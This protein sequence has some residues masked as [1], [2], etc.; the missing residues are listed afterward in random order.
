MNGLH[1]LIKNFLKGIFIDPFK[2]R[3][4][5]FFLHSI[6]PKSQYERLAHPY[7][8]F[9]N[10]IMYG[11]MKLHIQFNSFHFFGPSLPIQY[12]WL[13]NEQCGMINEMVKQ[14]ELLFKTKKE[15]QNDQCDYYDMV[16]PEQDFIK[17]YHRRQLAR[18]FVW[19]IYHKK[20]PYM[21]LELIAAIQSILVVHNSDVF[22]A[23]LH[24]AL[25]GR[26][27]IT[28]VP[29]W[30]IVEWDKHPDELG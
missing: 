21:L 12:K 30:N 17:L 22:M 4:F 10:A 8:D 11:E 14:R 13:N 1:D 26:C 16:F 27:L 6:R 23:T 18:D 25:Q 9:L 28:E 3:H 5:L 20:Q 29:C 7:S 2:R 19:L 24:Q 15:Y